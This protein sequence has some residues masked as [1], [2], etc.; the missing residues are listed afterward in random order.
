MQVLI[1]LA[2][3]LVFIAALVIKY[4]YDQGKRLDIIKED[5]LTHDAVVDKVVKR[6]ADLMKEDTFTGKD[7]VEFK[8]IYKRRLRLEEAMTNCVYGIDKD[9]II[10]KELITSVLQ[11][12]F[13]TQEDLYKVYPLDSYAIEP[14]WQF[15][16]LMER[17]YQT[18]KKGS[19]AY[20]IKKYHWDETRYNI[21]DGTV[22][23]YN[24]SVEDLQM[25][26]DEEITDPLSFRE[27]LAVVATLI[28]EEYKGM[29]VVDTLRT[30]NIDGFNMGTS[31]SIMSVNL[32]DNA[33]DWRAPRS[34][35]IYFQGK[36]IHAQFLTFN[37]E[38]E[39]RRVVQLIARYNNPGPL[40]EKRGYLVN[41][42]YDKSR[43]LALRPPVSEYWAVF[44]RKFVLS[45]NTLE[46][47]I[48][49]IIRNPATN[50]PELDAEGNQK[51][52]YV[53]AQL[54]MQLI[55]LLMRGQVTTAF[56]GRQGS[57][58]TTMMTAT[59]SQ[60]DARFNIR[61][62]EM[63]PEMYLREI[64]PQRN[65]LSAAETPTVT[66]AEIQ[67]AFKKSD[68]ALSIVGEVA[69]DIIAARMIQMGQV[70]S[71]FTI[72]SH[73]ANRTVDLVHALT[74]SIVSASGG[75]STPATVEPQV[76]DVIKVDVHLDYDVLGNRYIERVTEIIRLDAI[77]YPDQEPGES[78]DDY[79]I[80]LDK[81]Y[82]TRR[83]DRQTFTTRDVMRFDINNFS[84]DVA[85]DED[86]HAVFFSPELT[87]HIFSRLPRDEVSSWKEWVLA[88]WK[89]GESA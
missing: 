84:Y 82:Y 47:L 25:A 3:M 6:L 71:I 58:K 60:V 73:H 61:V 12:M 19:L 24:I 57:G 59:I 52:K 27:S 13:K 75:T 77:P 78:N 49:P 76:I 17:L 21:E 33:L 46:A 48:D 88:N 74:N 63:A 35:W 30:M 65:I 72:F 66:A 9:K 53:N 29:G 70:A 44:V 23:S 55:K 43:V 68:A 50:E 15:E 42:M 83:T 1:C 14:H 39:V 18:Y 26:Y 37:S 81:E 80:R 51:H 79:K 38:E 11:E 86:G 45:S 40:T 85:R 2:I 7:D 41:T 20:L 5:S 67:D 32:D 64:Y 28:Y 89:D 34:V 62:L 69:T 31:G 4:T 10:V 22:P 8:A 54:P 16:I 56:T 87:K 36:Y